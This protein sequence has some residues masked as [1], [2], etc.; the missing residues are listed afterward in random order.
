MSQQIQTLL[1][2]LRDEGSTAGV[3]QKS[4]ELLHRCLGNPAGA[5]TPKEFDEFK[6][7]VKHDSRPPEFT[8]LIRFT[9]AS[10]TTLSDMTS[11]IVFKKAFGP[12]NLK[13]SE[14]E[15]PCV[16]KVG[17]NEEVVF[18]DFSRI[19]HFFMQIENVKIENCRYQIQGKRALIVCS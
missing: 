4:H 19:E 15:Q 6:L 14:Y 3:R 13:T 16:I 10:A 11:S 1:T 7:H 9:S 12:K 2:S 8:H 18:T 5:P 17:T